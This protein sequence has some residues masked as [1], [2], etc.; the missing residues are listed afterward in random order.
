MTTHHTALNITHIGRFN[1]FAPR[2]FH[3]IA[4]EPALSEAEWVGFTLLEVSL[5][6]LEPS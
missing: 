2:T 4:E 1:R 6:L 5:N 3:T